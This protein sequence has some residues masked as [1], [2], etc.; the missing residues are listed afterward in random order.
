MD[1]LWLQAPMPAL[2]VRGVADGPDGPDGVTVQANSAALHWAQ[3]AGVSEAQLQ[4]LGRQAH[5]SG[6]LAGDLQ[7]GAVSV[8]C[9]P[10]RQSD[11]SL[12]KM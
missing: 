11:G 1:R 6:A 8:H 12:P 10:V 5:T 2:R 9:V 4:A 7:L 3:A